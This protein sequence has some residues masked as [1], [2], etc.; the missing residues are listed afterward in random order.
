MPGSGGVRGDTSGAKRRRRA[1]GGFLP[2]RSFLI[3]TALALSVLMGTAVIEYDTVRRGDEQAL[4]LERRLLQS[5]IVQ[6]G[7]ENPLDGTTAS[8]IAETAR[9]QGLAFDTG[10]AQHALLDKQGRI[11]GFFTWDAPNTYR[12]F[13][14]LIFVVIVS[15]AAVMLFAALAI[16]Q[17]RRARGKL[18]ETEARATKAAETDKLTGLPNHDKM[19]DLLECAL[20]ERAHGGMIVFA[21]VAIDGLEETQVGTLGADELILTVAQRLCAA[22]PG[23]AVCGRMAAGEFAS[24]FE[25][26]ASADAQPLLRA[27]LDA[28]AQPFWVDKVVRLTTQDGFAQSPQH[29]TTHNELSRC[30]ELALRSAAKRGPGTLA[31]F[32]PSIDEACSERKLIQRELPRALAA[33]E[34][35]LHFQPIVSAGTGDVLGCEALLRWPH[36]V[37]GWIPPAT[38][39][40]VAEQMGL[41]D[42]LG[43]YVLH[44]ALQEAKRWPDIYVSRNLSP[45]PVA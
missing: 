4:A 27:A 43:S 1:S 45:M 42:Q 39:I 31:M 19:L 18:H 8:M 36:A 34:L 40:P 20:E 2:P 33:Q 28:L 29:A 41:M 26:D 3:V 6:V 9:L 44:R 23:H 16:W 15:F 32:D 21:L 10:R 12:F 24:F 14:P 35:E 25:I 13:K 22:L 38:F 30:A 37:R 5:A 11:A 7:Q 17:L